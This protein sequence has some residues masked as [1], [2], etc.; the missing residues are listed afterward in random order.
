[1]KIA[2]TLAFGS[3]S[4]LSRRVV[5]CVLVSALVCVRALVF[6]SILVLAFLLLI[7]VLALTLALLFMC[8]SPTSVR[9]AQP[10]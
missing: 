2:P 8:N 10:G 9:M 7:L 1:M 5:T 4:W 6:V 3:A